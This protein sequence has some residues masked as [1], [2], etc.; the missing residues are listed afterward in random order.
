MRLN[1]REV[2]RGIIL[3]IW[4]DSSKY[5]H[6]IS[7]ENYKEKNVFSMSSLLF[8]VITPCLEYEKMYILILFQ[9]FT[10]RCPNASLKISAILSLV[11][12]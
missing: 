7:R 2:L 10:E 5:F 6:E 9:K 3:L 11:L 1:K 12:L 4:A 8:V